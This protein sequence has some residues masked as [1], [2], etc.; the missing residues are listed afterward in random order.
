MRIATLGFLTL[1]ALSS[2]AALAD[3]PAD[4]GWCCTGRPSREE[5]ALGGRAKS[6]S[7]QHESLGFYYRENRSPG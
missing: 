6:R 7:V 1:L 2:T 4:T 5:N 3:G